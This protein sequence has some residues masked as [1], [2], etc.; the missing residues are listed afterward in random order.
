MTTPPP[1]RE[2]PWTLFAVA[3][4]GVLLAGAFGLTVNFLAG[5]Q[6]GDQPRNRAVV[7]AMPI[8]PPD[9]SMEGRMARGMLGGLWWGAILSLVFTAQAGN[10][11][12]ARC[13][14]GLALPAFGI[15]LLTAL[16]GWPILGTGWGCLLGA[17]V[18]LRLALRYL[19]GR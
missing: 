2:R 10:I 3:L 11:T 1:E 7:P 15:I 6:P 19:R 8:Q 16:V 5:E 18:G 9:P 14:F 12:G 17:L 4:T 13:T